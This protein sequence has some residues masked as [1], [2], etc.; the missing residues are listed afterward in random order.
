MALVNAPRI[1]ESRLCVLMP[2]RWAVEGERNRF[3]LI[4]C[5]TAHTD[6]RRVLTVVL[7][8]TQGQ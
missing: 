7:T 3:N 4:V 5:S 8:L 2:L 1:N 6:I